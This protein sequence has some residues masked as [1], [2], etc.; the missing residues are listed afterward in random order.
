VLATNQ[1]GYP[2]YSPLNTAGAIIQNVPNQMSIPT[3]V[4]STRENELH[5]AYTGLTGSGTGGSPIVSYI[6]L[7]DKGN[8]SP[9]EAIIG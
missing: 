2:T 4:A 9:Y 7:W 3:R 5:L 6:V 8:N 1:Y